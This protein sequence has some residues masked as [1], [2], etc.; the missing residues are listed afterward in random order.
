MSPAKKPESSPLVAPWLRHTLGWLLGAGR[1]VLILAALAGVL[2]GGAYIGY[3]KLKPKIVALPEYQIGIEQVE[4][5]PQPAW[6]HADV[7][8]EVFSDARLDGMLSLMDDDLVDRIKNAFAQHP[9][10]A[11]VARVAKRYPSSVQVELVYR[12]PLCMVE[13][14]GGVYAVDADG[15]LLPSKDF[16]G[17]EATRY[18]RLA[19]VDREPIVP[20]GRIW[21][22][23]RVLGGAKIADAL[24]PVWDSMRLAYILPL[25]DEPTVGGGPGHRASEPVFMLLTRVDATHAGTQIRWGYAPDAKIPGELSA[26]E[27]VGRLK[28]YVS[29][30]DSLDLPTGKPQQLDVRTMGHARP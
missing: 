13:V 17:N 14:P 12:R 8:G 7:R 16:S 6:I 29:E 11:R 20:A 2:G 4:I 10:V 22:D 5:T 30:H 25:P 3:R 9:W 24:G 21:N 1:P 15:V 28:Q 23:T 26:D 27:K 18:P 19:R